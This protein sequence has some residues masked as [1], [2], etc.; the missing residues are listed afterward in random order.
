MFTGSNINV[1]RKV[2]VSATHF[3]RSLNLDKIFAFPG[4]SPLHSA[5]GSRSV[6]IVKL[7]LDREADVNKADKD[8]KTFLGILP[9]F[10]QS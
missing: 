9:L 6:E 2:K 1:H 5:V 10:W 3:A 7:L 4:I 8:G